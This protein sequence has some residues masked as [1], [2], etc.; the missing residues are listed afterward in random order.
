MGNESSQADKMGE[1]YQRDGR[2]IGPA[3]SPTPS[4]DAR[5][6]SERIIGPSMSPLPSDGETNQQITAS[7]KS[8]K[9]KKKRQR[10][11]ADTIASPEAGAADIAATPV[12]EGNVV[13]E[14]TK[15]YRKKKTQKVG[16]LE[17]DGMVMEGTQPEARTR[18]M[19]ETPQSKRKSR[20]RSKLAAAHDNETPVQSGQQDQELE[21][22]AQADGLQ[23]QDAL[24][25]GE[26]GVTHSPQSSKKKRPRNKKRSDPQSPETPHLISH[27]MGGS[28]PS[29]QQQTVNGILKYEPD[30]VVD[31]EED[32][33]PSSLPN[34]RRRGSAD[35]PSSDL[36]ATQFKTERLTDDENEGG[37]EQSHGQFAGP[38][39]SGLGDVT[40]DSD[41]E[42]I[43]G[44]DPD[45][46][47]L[48]QE[49]SQ[50]LHKQEIKFDSDEE[51]I[52]D[53]RTSQERE[54]DA[55]LPDLQ[56]SQVKTEPAHSESD[57]ESESPSA[58]R[59]ERLE[60]SRSR[61]MSR[62]SASRLADDDVSSL[63]PSMPQPYGVT[64]SII[65][66]PTIH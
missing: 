62:A 23:N 18:D 36:P 3:M 49:D 51:P 55:A 11:G 4:V 40:T 5:S 42:A 44:R 57:A 2:L 22:I 21:D 25:D 45:Q 24:L 38:A 9:K 63:Y 65:Y 12:D 8:S 30:L 35:S 58:A 61:S 15:K 50:W 59:L 66:P 33:I 26:P 48:S 16:E 64:R 31:A 17:D 43:P 54:D 27:A 19:D 53:T 37:Q 29:A 13:P 60:R 14:S 6:E 28:P 1:V 10:K 34:D 39:V 47:Y 41:S 20:K 56:P 32:V 52:T 46:E 7:P